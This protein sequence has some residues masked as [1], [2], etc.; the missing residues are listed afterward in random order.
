METHSSFGVRIE[1]PPRLLVYRVFPKH[2]NVDFPVRKI[3]IASGNVSYA[4][5]TT[6]GVKAMELHRRTKEK[7]YFL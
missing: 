3:H 5:K 1:A 6:S 7:G 4:I 2:R